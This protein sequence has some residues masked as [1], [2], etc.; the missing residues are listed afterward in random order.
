MRFLAPFW[1]F[2][3]GEAAMVIHPVA[4]IKIGEGGWSR[5]KS[6]A[7]IPGAHYDVQLHIGESRDSGVCASRIRE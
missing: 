6:L 5:L 3:A 1:G 2:L 4:R 7:G